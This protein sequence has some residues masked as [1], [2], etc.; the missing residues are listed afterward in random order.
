MKIV[1]NTHGY[2][3]NENDEYVE[4]IGEHG[5][6]FKLPINLEQSNSWADDKTAEVFGCPSCHVVFFK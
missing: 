1:V 3:W 2:K 5:D 6:F 4:D